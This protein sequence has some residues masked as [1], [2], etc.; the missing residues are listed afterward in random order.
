MPENYITHILKL[1]MKT[2]LPIK[3][4]SVDFK[5]V[6]QVMAACVTD[7]GAEAE[8]CSNCL[9]G[10][11]H[12]VVVL[13]IGPKLAVSPGAMLEVLAS[14]CVDSVPNKD[15]PLE[16][17]LVFSVRLDNSANMCWIT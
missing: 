14:N 8:L 7:S 11:E 4:S 5:E 12:F 17:C 2:Q 1:P 15:A 16:I 13:G 3:T 10:K 6:Q 9:E